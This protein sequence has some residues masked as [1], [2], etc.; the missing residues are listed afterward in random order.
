MGTAGNIVLPPR[1]LEDAFAAARASGALCISD[2]VQVGVGRMGEAFWC[3]EL[4]NVVPDIVTMGKPLGN[5]HPI[6]AVVTT[7]SIADAFDT[8]MKYFQYIRRQSGLLRNR[9]SSTRRRRRRRSSG[10]CAG[11]RRL[12]PSAVGGLKERQPMIGDVRGQG[13]Y[14]GVDS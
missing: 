11:G 9:R 4:G 3:F 5:G 10:P 1:Y 2:E 12:F 8:G 6:A 7:R 13:L 14:L